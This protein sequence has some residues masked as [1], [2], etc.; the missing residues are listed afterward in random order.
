M[1]KA[2]KVFHV[3]ASAFGVLVTLALAI[4]IVAS[5]ISIIGGIVMVVISF[6]STPASAEES[7][8]AGLLIGGIALAISGV[9]L[10]IMTTFFMIL[11]L[12]GTIFAFIGIKKDKKAIY[13]INII[14]GGLA[15]FPFMAYLPLGL[16]AIVYL[17]LYLVIIII[18][19]LTPIGW[20]LLSYVIA[21]FGSLLFLV[22]SILGGVFGIITEKKEKSQIVDTCIEEIEVKEE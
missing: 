9:V 1:K 5:I 2:S 7:Y 13:I 20:I 15:A 4:I 10:T 22:F 18:I 17:I 8:S 14:F 12:V 11:L 21:S 16:Y 3:L 6:V 19:F